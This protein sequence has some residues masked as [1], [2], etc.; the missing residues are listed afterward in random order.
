MPNNQNLI[1][2]DTFMFN[3]SGLTEFDDREHNQQHQCINKYLFAHA[4]I[5]IFKYDA[6]WFWSNM[7][8][9][10]KYINNNVK[11]QFIQ[12]TSTQS[13]IQQQQTALPQME[14]VFDKKKHFD[15]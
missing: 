3:K 13:T 14:N 2:L 9:E 11:F 1:N 7:K 8:I 6:C 10:Y 15:L 12:P 5:V 4:T